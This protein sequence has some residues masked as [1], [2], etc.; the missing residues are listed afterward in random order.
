MSI[1]YYLSF[2]FIVSLFSCKE[3]IDIALAE[4]VNKLIIEGEVHDGVGPYYVKLSRSTK[5]GV[6]TTF[7]PHTPTSVIITD[8]EG[9]KDSLVKHADG[10]YKTTSIQGK[11]GNTYFL[12]VNDNSGI[13]T[14]ESKLNSSPTI[15]SFYFFFFLTQEN[16]NPTIVVN[17]P[18][19]EENFYRY[20]VRKNG[21]TPE[22]NYVSDDKL[23]NGSKWRFTAFREDFK[24]GDSGEFV[25]LG[26]DKA[27]FNYW[28]ILVQNQAAVSG[29]NESASPT[30]PPTN[31]KGGEVLG[32]FSAHSRK[33]KKFIV[34]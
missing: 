34:P 3:R 31:I 15:D 32:Y 5:F 1:K 28:N 13:Y 14:A 25:F 33:A 22:F 23:I 19:T 29:G 4:D 17:E 27:N 7:L 18:A 20:F 12:T 8:N 21:K 30:N 9:N 11:V 6:S 2:L 24:K 16:I 10:I 26:I